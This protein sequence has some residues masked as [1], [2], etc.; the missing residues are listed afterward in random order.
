M[1]PRAWLM[2]II[3]TLPFALPLTWTRFNHKMIYLIYCTTV[4][5]DAF[6]FS[7]FWRLLWDRW[8]MACVLILQH[9][10]HVGTVVQR[11]LVL[12]LQGNWLV[13][14]FQPQLKGMIVIAPKHHWKI[15][16]NL[17]IK[18]SSNISDGSYALSLPYSAS[19]HG[20]TSTLTYRAG[21]YQVSTGLSVTLGAS[22]LAVD[23]AR[24]QWVSSN[25]T[26]RV[27]G[28]GFC[29]DLT[30]RTYVDST[31]C[32]VRSHAVADIV[33]VFLS[34]FSLSTFLLLYIG[35]VII[36]SAGVEMCSLFAGLFSG[37]AVETGSICTCFEGERCNVASCLL[38]CWM[39][40]YFQILFKERVLLLLL[41]GFVTAADPD[42]LDIAR[43]PWATAIHLT[44]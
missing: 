23:S 24:Y 28:G 42:H 8:S 32:A 22:S 4:D 37:D 21:G 12:W 15:V 43:I 1:P 9:L 16:W 40:F 27:T 44:M 19:E 36:Q 25:M 29:Q 41:L 33:L 26:D 18:L 7:L 2:V 31:F 20:T 14:I 11:L 10:L 17:T 30:T 13:R 3:G 39:F 5:C 34:F 35:F 38:C 6:L